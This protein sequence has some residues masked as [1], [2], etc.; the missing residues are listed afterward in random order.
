[1]DSEI[2]GPLESTNSLE[3]R[4]FINSLGIDSE[5]EQY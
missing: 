4:S 1:M 5:I 2:E 3:I